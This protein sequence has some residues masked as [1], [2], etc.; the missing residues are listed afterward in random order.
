MLWES[1]GLHW[2]GW[3]QTTETVVVLEK[4]QKQ[5]INFTSFHINHRILYRNYLQ[6]VKNQSASVMESRKV[7][8]HL[9][10]PGSLFFFFFNPSCGTQPL[11]ILLNR[12]QNGPLSFSRN[13]FAGSSHRRPSWPPDLIIN[14]GSVQ[15]AAIWWKRRLSGEIKPLYHSVIVVSLSRSLFHSLAPPILTHHP[16]S[17]MPHSLSSY[18][19]FWGCQCVR[20][21]RVVSSRGTFDVLI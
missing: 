4:R 15:G 11:V 5:H 2:G 17:P 13:T 8:Q 20:L 7:P 1:P 19:K 9:Q 10:N 3:G 16:P 14:Q 6:K 18:H 12:D 21:R